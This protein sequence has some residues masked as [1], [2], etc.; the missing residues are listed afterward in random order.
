MIV[1]GV[2]KSKQDSFFLILTLGALT[3]LSPFSIDMYLPAFPQIA[4]DLLTTTSKVSLSLSSYFVG[5]ASGQLF[6][7]PLL[8]RFG[9]KRPLYFG[10]IIYII[11]CIG[12]LFTKSTDSLIAFRFVQ[13]IGGCA[14]GVTSM[15]MVRD[16]FSTK[17][18]SKVF[19]LLI[20]VLGV[21]PLVAPT[22]GGYASIA[23][24]W[25]S[26]FVILGL[27][28]FLMLLAARFY[29]KES[30][31]PDRTIVLRLKPIAK[32]Y[33]N[34]LKVPQFYT[35]ALTTAVGFSGLFVYIAGSP[36]LF[37]D[38]FKVTPLVYGWIFAFNA[39]G[40][41][42][43]SQFNILLIKKFENAKILKFGLLLQ[44]IAGIFLCVGTLND[45]LGLTATVFLLFTFLGSL[46][47]ISPNASS[48]ALAPFSKNAGSAA[49]LMGFLQM[50]L[51]AL[52]SSV[53]GI[54]NISSSTPV[55]IALAISSATALIILLFGHSKIKHEKFVS[56]DS[57]IVT[58]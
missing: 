2:E 30:H 47:L 34:I 41:V 20:L 21:S 26:V 49:A 45:W 18:S 23:W 37:M 28:A 31:H 40:F 4:S 55:V 5:L 32:N 50:S 14:A 52:A 33:F 19:S 58:H 10:L 46:G 35:Y 29:L 16:L 27:I 6:Y 3:A 22:V 48:L 7:G 25:H 51:G 53:I 24:G 15:S 13:A 8:D 43:V 39:M 42:F 9:R 1:D 44:T 12:C 54:L 11:A 17:E 56:E 38:V 36:V 57:V